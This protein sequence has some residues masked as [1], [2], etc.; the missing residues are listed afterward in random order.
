MFPQRILLT[1]TLLHCGQ[2]NERTLVVDTPTT[3][4]PRRPRR[5]HLLRSKTI[6]VDPATA[7][8]VRSVPDMKQTFGVRAR[9]HREAF[10][11]AV[12][13]AD[14][15]RISACEVSAVTA[16]IAPDPARGRVVGAGVHT[17]RPIWRL[18]Q[19]D[20]HWMALRPALSTTRA[21]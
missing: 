21:L 15:L 1:S 14:R 6:P 4:L 8:R 17:A 20:S 3:S 16:M 9:E 7:Q 2:L 11:P 5:L 18:S 13:F 12:A 10:L 19:S